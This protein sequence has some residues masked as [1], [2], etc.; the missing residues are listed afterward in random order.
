MALLIGGSV[1]ADAARAPA[2][3]TPL[4]RCA[5]GGRLRLCRLLLAFRADSDRASVGGATALSLALGFACDV[6][7]GSVPTEERP[8]GV[9]GSRWVRSSPNRPQS[10][11]RLTRDGPQLPTPKTDPKL[12]GP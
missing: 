10:D 1:A 11:P 12:T 5:E 2:N 4:M 6:G 8:S 3:I 9:F 7:G